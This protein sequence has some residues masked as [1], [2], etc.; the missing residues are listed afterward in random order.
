M[1][2]EF[3]SGVRFTTPERRPAAALGTNPVGVLV[4]SSRPVFSLVKSRGNRLIRESDV[5]ETDGEILL[6]PCAFD[7]EGKTRVCLRCAAQAEHRIALGWGGSVPNTE[8][9]VRCSATNVLGLFIVVCHRF[10][11]FVF[12]FVFG[13]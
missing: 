12:V 10:P 5:M 11:V 6:D 9:M 3:L 13:E 1:V 8:A 4:R 7:C 2:E